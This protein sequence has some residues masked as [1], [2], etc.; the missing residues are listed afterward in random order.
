M[1][2]TVLAP[3]SGLL[4]QVPAIVCG[5]GDSPTGPKFKACRYVPWLGLPWRVGVAGQA[6]LGQ[7]GSQMCTCVCVCAHA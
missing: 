2:E 4:T 6:V 1:Q 3:G 5:P 7:V